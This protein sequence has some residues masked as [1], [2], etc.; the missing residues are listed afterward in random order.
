VLVIEH[1]GE[2]AGFLIFVRF[3]SNEFRG[4]CVLLDELYLE[5]RHRGGT[6]LA[7]LRAF[8]SLMRA[9]SI[10]AIDLEVLHKNAKVHSLYRRAGFVNDRTGYTK[11]V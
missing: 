6:G 9:E 4:P 7:V 11:K 3:W 1:A 8:E 2:P 10:K 5:P